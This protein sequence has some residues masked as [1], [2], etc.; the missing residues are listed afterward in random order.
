[1]FLGPLSGALVGAGAT[2]TDFIND[3]DRDGFQWRDVKN[4]V[5]GLGMDAIGMIPVVGDSFGT[6]GKVTRSLV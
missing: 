5:T 4:L 6:M 3:L 1:M 2:V